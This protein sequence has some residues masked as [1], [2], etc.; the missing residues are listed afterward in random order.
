MAAGTAADSSVFK[1]SAPRSFDRLILFH[2]QFDDI[3]G[4]L[5][6]F[7]VVVCSAAIEDSLGEE[8]LA[9]GL[10]GVLVDL[11]AVVLDLVGDQ[12]AVEFVGLG[13]DLECGVLA[14][15]LLWRGR[16]ASCGPLRIFQGN[17]GVVLLLLLLLARLRPVEAVR[18]GLL[19]G[20][21]L[22]IPNH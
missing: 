2:F 18:L 14:Q 1:F 20:H 5:F 9:E 11:L 6:C 10:A 21:V 15:I 13:Q 4:C 12:Q 7:V 3:G 16:L 19:L 22:H 17:A 8:E